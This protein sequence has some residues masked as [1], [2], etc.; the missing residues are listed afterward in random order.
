MALRIK[1]LR[2]DNDLS[3]RYIAN[4]LGCTQSAYSKYEKGERNISY[5]ALIKLADFYDVS[6]DYLMGRNNKR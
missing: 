1:E 2:E 4:I 6:L 5:Q 3:Q